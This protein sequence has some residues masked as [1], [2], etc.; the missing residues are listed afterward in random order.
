MLVLFL[1][2]YD[3]QMEETLPCAEKLVF[4]TR[5]Q[6]AASAN[7]AE[8]QHGTKL[9]PYKCSHCGLWHLSSN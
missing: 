7:V 5:E 9:K 1:F 4:D 6:A 3:E 8:W 2:C